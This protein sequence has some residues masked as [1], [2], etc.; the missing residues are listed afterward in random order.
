MAAKGGGSNSGWTT[1]DYKDAGF[2]MQIGGA[3]WD[4]GAKASGAWTKYYEAKANSNMMRINAQLTRYN[5]KAHLEDAES[6]MMHAGEVQRAGEEGAVNRYLQLGQDIG[7]IYSGA[8]GGGIDVSSKVVGQVDSAAR[9]MAQRD[10]DAMN[11][12]TAQAANQYVDEARNAR[13]AYIS[14]LTA[15]R[16]QEIQARYNKRIAASNARLG[17]WSAAASLAGNVGL[18]FSMYGAG[19]G[20]GGGGGGA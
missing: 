1:Q 8:A 11:R 20:G 5:A 13:L 7:R 18:A 14:D 2:G 16:M 3:L 4:F 15:A 10:V 17:T 12:S 9:T 6:A 19:G